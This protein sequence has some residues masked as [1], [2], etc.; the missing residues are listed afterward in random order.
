[1]GYV[2]YVDKVIA[3]FSGGGFCHAGYQQALQCQVLHSVCIWVTLAQF[4]AVEMV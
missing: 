4:Q 2:V 1:M 3:I